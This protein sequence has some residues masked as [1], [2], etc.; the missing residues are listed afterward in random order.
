[1]DIGGN[2]NL[3]FTPNVRE[4]IA[5][6]ARADPSKLADRRTIGLVVRGL[7]HEIDAFRVA[8][9]GNLLCHAADKFLGLNNA[10]TQNERGAFAADRH[11]PDTQWFWFGH[12]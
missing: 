11:L 9:F 12:E 6:F 7:E 8:H 3:Q 1:M 2:W 4:D 5:P 10:R